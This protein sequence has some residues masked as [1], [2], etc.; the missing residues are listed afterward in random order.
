MN[1]YI[2]EIQYKTAHRWPKTQIEICA[3]WEKFPSLTIPCPWCC[4]IEVS[5]QNII[6]IGFLLSDISK[7]FNRVISY[8]KWSEAELANDVT[9]GLRRKV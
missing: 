1:Q 8:E 4:W 3:I 5:R 2:H 6:F 9:D 7:D